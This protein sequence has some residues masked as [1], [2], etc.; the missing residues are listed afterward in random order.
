MSTKTIVKV[1]AGAAVVWFFFIRKGGGG[2]F[3]PSDSADK[4]KNPTGV[5][6][7]AA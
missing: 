6:K 2:F 1:A 4:N 3:G 7:G 5:V